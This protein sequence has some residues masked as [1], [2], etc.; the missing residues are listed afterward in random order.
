MMSLSLSLAYCLV[1]APII[2][3]LKSFKTSGFSISILSTSSDSGITSSRIN[4]ESNER[5]KRKID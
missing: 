3:M 1:T 4:L 2:I 5:C